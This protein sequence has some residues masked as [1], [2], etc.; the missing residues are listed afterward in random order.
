M[1]DDELAGFPTLTDLEAALALQPEAVIVSNPTASHLDVAIPA[2][3]MGCHLF[4][5]KP[6]SHT[7]DRI[8]E[9]KEAVLHGGGKVLV[10]FQFRF[11]PGLQQVGRLLNDGAI[12][13]LL[14]VHAHWGEYL[15]GWHPWEDYRQGYSARLDLGGGVVLTL[16]HPLDYL[17]WLVGEVSAL[18][19]FTG[20]LGDLELQV[21]D[22]A[23]I[24]LR[25][26]SGALGSIHLDYNQRPPSHCLEMIGTEGTIR[27]DNADG[28]ARHYRAEEG[29]WK[30]HPAPDGF[31]R[32]QLFL[33]QMRHFLGVVRDQEEPSCTL[34]DGIKALQLALAVHASQAQGKIICP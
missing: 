9:L 12:G 32:N 30:A 19:A 6:I 21:E 16:C 27:W 1:P 5:E 10:G 28:A 4:L 25:F 34:D 31:E 7:L 23:E 17:R 14:S 8:D 24:G 13:R 22:T 2:A 20:K 29:Q 26:A 11:H 3:Q 15:P 18:W 33:A